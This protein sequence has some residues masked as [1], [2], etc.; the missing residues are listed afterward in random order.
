MVAYIFALVDLGCGI[1]EA[2]AVS[3]SHQM[4]VYLWLTEEASA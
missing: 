2:I 1:R 4:W 3:Q